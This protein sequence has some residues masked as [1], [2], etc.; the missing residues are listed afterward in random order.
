[1]LLPSWSEGSILPL[2]G[3][4]VE[5]GDEKK[6]S[7]SSGRYLSPHPALLTFRLVFYFITSRRKENKIMELSNK[8]RN[9]KKA[10]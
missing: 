4:R 8:E 2:E 5:D 6:E 1:M 10:R 7:S 3:K 9:E